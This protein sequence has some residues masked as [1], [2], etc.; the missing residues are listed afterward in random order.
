MIVVT[1]GEGFIGKN[2]IW[3]LK[4]LEVVSLDT[5]T[6]DLDFIRSWF[7]I[8]AANLDFVYHIGAITDT[9]EMSVAKFDEYNVNMSMFIWNICTEHKIPLVYASSAAT[10]GG[11]EHGFNDETP[12]SQ[13][14]PL[15]PY[16]WSKH[17]F[18][19]WV[20]LQAKAHN[21]PP[22]WAGLKFFNVY[23]CCED[24]KGRMAS[25]VYHTFNQVLKTEKV[26]LFKSHHLD[27][28]DGEQLRDFI[29]VDD[30]VDVCLYMSTSLPAPG[31]YNV[32]TGKARSFN[33]LA[34]AVFKSLN[35]TT[36]LIEYFDTP[37]ELRE[38]YQ[39]FTEATT[40]KLRLAGYKKP[41]TELEVGVD[42]Y[43]KQLLQRTL[44]LD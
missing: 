15:N 39:Y 4:D 41:F 32:G 18:D 31:I 11:G 10:Y 35:H 1:G 30:V 14:E 21:T 22:F 33:D 27:Y 16:G 38:Q 9:T 19:L 24:H 37:I 7:T 8:N 23:G 36:W 12:L 25:M 43:C 34:K 28:K 40:D 17:D 44:G 6:L 13:L 20:T 42:K 3:R 2:L 26:R 5:K 29:F